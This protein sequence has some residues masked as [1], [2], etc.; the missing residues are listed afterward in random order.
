MRRTLGL[1]STVLALVVASAGGATA[2]Q[3]ASTVDRSSAIVEL[4]GDP[5]STSRGRG[6]PTGRRSISTAQRAV[7]RAQ[8]N[9]I[10][11]EFK[12]WLSANAPKAKVTGSFDIAL[13]A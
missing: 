6:R 4:V 3:P 1:F 10:R 12:Q 7:E 11:N 9:Q 2:A 8:L 13:H 5:L